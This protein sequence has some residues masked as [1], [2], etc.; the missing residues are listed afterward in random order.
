MSG[1]R[2]M[3]FD[4]ENDPQEFADLGADPACA[5]VRERMQEN[6]LDWA[7]KDQNRITMSDE[8][9]DGYDSGRQPTGGILTGYWDEAELA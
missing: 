7:L 5:A 3:L 4:L 6:L 2:P 9:I 1:F 8:R